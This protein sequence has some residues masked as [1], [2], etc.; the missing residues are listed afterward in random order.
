MNSISV[1]LSNGQ[2]S[3]RCS[4]RVFSLQ[5]RPVE[6]LTASC[7]LRRIP[8]LFNRRP[9][10][11]LQVERPA[12]YPA[13][14]T[15]AAKGVKSRVWASVQVRA[16]PKLDTCQTSLVLVSCSPALELPNRYMQTSSTK[17]LLQQY[18]RERS[19]TSEPRN[20]ELLL[21]A[22]GR[23][24]RYCLSDG[25]GRPWHECSLPVPEPCRTRRDP[26]S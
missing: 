1:S 21:Q 8:S 5:S 3:P 10:S 20:T 13:Q 22:D 11:V 19:P 25:F 15:G 23:R 6:S 9:P 12:C 24:R 17:A 4:S 7:I 16:P 2:A 26:G 18:S 14:H